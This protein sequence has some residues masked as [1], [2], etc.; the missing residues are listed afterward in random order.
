MELQDSWPQVIRERRLRCVEF[1]P[2]LIA[3]FCREGQTLVGLRVVQG[4]P[5]DALLLRSTVNVEFNT[6][7][8]IFAHPSFEPV[9]L[10]ARLRRVAVATERA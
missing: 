2:E 1:D 9:E 6:I 10:G 7:D 5:A 8:L 3:E 4:V